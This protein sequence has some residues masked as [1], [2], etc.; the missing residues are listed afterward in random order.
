VVLKDVGGQRGPVVSS[1][2]SPLWD[3]SRKVKGGR[4]DEVSM[5]EGYHEDQGWCMRA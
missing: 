3:G 2:S 4:E 1:V 5:V